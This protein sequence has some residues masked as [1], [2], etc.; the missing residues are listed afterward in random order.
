MFIVEPGEFWLKG[1]AAAEYIAQAAN[2]AYK[3]GAADGLA[4]G[5]NI[6]RKEALLVAGAVVICY[7]GYKVYKCLSKQGEIEKLKRDL[8]LMGQCDPK[9]FFKT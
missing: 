9:D 5:V 7:G 6:G 2:A 3:A 1:A 4:R 8:E